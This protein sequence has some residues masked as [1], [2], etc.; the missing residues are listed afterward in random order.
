MTCPRGDGPKGQVVLLLVCCWSRIC[1]VSGFGPGTGTCKK[2]RL[3]KM[4]KV[5]VYHELDMATDTAFEEYDA[6]S[7]YEAPVLVHTP[8]HLSADLMTACKDWHTAARRF[9]KAFDRD[10]N[11]FAG[12][13]DLLDDL[14]ADC[15]RG[16]FVNNCE[17][18]DG[19]LA[20]GVEEVP[21]GYYVYISVWDKHGNL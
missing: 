12:I 17:W 6:E 9:R 15:E 10:G 3:S 19:G 5:R 20:M 11:D 16:D 7:M 2:G 4:K 13:A 14:E 1:T 21:D 8:C 18:G